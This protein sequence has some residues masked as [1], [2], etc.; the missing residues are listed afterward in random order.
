MN[1]EEDSHSE[2]QPGLR[3]RTLG[4]QLLNLRN[5]KPNRNLICAIQ[6]VAAINAQLRHDGSPYEWSR[7][8]VWP[9]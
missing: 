8:R 7:L 6:S 2:Q 4:L 9:A 5:R 3:A 1:G